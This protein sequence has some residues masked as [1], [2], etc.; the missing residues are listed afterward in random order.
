MESKDPTLFASTVTAGGPMTPALA[1][2]S[3]TNESHRGPP[4]LRNPASQD[5]QDDLTQLSYLHEP[6]GR[7][8]VAFL[9]L[10]RNG[11]DGWTISAHSL[12]FIFSF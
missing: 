7:W 11:R 2:S 9:R 6:G 8:T 1:A 3:T 12:L 4:P 10:D 5:G